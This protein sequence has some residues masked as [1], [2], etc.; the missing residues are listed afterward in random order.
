MDTTTSKNAAKKC[1]QCENRAAAIS[2]TSAA[3]ADVKP[4]WSDVHQVADSYYY[5]QPF[6]ATPIT[7][8]AIVEPNTVANISDPISAPTYT[9]PAT[10]PAWLVNDDCDTVAK[11]NVKLLRMEQ[12]WSES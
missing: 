10:V 7:V 1:H 5:K 12:H 8:Y 9:G 3:V 4:P 11:V 2:P 6:R